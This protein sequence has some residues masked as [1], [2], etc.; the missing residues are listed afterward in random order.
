MHSQHRTIPVWL[1]DEYDATQASFIRLGSPH[2]RHLLGGNNPSNLMYILYPTGV[3]SWVVVYICRFLYG[4][5]T[6]YNSDEAHYTF[7]L[8]LLLLTSSLF[9]SNKR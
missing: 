7:L 8:V 4:V 3:G 6:L 2:F 5:G 9:E 1:Q